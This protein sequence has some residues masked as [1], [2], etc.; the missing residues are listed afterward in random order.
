MKEWFK[1][2]FHHAPHLTSLR[3]CLR[4]R[5]LRRLER[6]AKRDELLAHD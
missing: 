1:T 4:I 3:V 6:Y 5:G 2:K